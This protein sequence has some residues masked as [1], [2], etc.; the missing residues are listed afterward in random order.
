MRPILLAVLL[1]ACGDND[2][3]ACKR[4]RGLHTFDGQL[5]EQGPVFNCA[6]IVTDTVNFDADPCIQSVTFDETT[7]VWE[8]R[9]ECGGSMVYF[10]VDDY[11]E[12]FY[13]MSVDG[14]PLC[15]YDVVIR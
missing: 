4:P 8:G 12:A 7:C 10:R 3:E 11:P 5:S 14:V 15:S 6:A 9:G 2:D 1:L 13:L